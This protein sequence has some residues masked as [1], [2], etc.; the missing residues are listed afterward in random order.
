MKPPFLPACASLD[1]RLSRARADIA[2]AVASSS[3]LANSLGDISIKPTTHGSVPVSTDQQV[4]L[5]HEAHLPGL[6]GCARRRLESGQHPQRFA[7]KL[8]DDDS[9]LEKNLHLLV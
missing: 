3:G 8:L 7:E 2:K 5:D 1:G 4:C 9:R 6:Q